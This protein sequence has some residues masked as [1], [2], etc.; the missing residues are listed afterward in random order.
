[1][2]NPGTKYLVP[3]FLICEMLIYY[4]VRYKKGDG[5]YVVKA[6]SS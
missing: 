5:S 3:G 1:M 2:G 4:N 6:V